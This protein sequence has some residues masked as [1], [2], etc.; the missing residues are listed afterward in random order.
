VLHHW[1]YGDPP[2]ERCGFHSIP[3]QLLDF[4]DIR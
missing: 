3:T 2:V 4:V 1:P